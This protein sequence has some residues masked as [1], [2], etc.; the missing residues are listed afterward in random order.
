MA[1]VDDLVISGSAQMVKDFIVMIQEEFTLKHVNFLTSE[2]SVEFLGRTIK[3]LKNGNITME[4]SQKFIDELLKIFEVT[5]KVTTTGLK[6]QA[7]PEDQK[8]QCDRVIHQ[9]YRSAVGKLLWMAQLRDDLKYPVKELSRSLINPQDQDIK[10]L[11]HLLKY[12][13]QT[14]DFVFV[15]EPQ[16][17]VRNQEGKFPVQIVS[18]SDSD[19]AGCQKSR[20][21]TSGSLISVFN[22]NIQSTS[23]T[24]ASIAHSSAESELYAMTQASVESLA[25]KNFIQEFSSA[26][27]SA[28][29]SIVIQTDSSAGKSMASRLGI[30]R[31]SKHIELKYLWIQDEIKEG[32]L[33]LKKVGT[34]FNPSDVLT[35]Y[36]PAS[37]LGQHLPRLNIFKVHSQRSKSV[38]LSAQTG[39]SVQCSSHP[40]PPSTSTSSITTTPLSVFMFSVNLD[41]QEHLRQ[42]LSQASRRIKRVLTPPRRGSGDQESIALRRQH[43]SHQDSEVQENQE[44]IAEVRE[45]VH[46]N[47]DSGVHGQ[48]HV[49]PQNHESTSQWSSWIRSCFSVSVS[50]SSLSWRRRQDQGRN[51]EN[52]EEINQRLSHLYLRASRVMSYVLF[53]SVFCSFVIFLFNSLHPSN[54]PSVQKSSA[55]PFVTEAV[56]I[57]TQHQSQSS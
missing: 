47:S 30:S 10:N 43:V 46:E 22:V 9:K 55:Q 26:I 34:H 53:Y 2:N 33:E 25:I 7:L 1:Y 11:I 42:R 29:V 54:Q 3:R 13:N 57:R 38:L 56:N 31:R 21:S 19:W 50:L 49:P 14:R 32:K 52:Q 37:V 51:Q 27:L 20:R 39:Q 4:F 12:V 8:V 6:L 17:P 24:Q 23:R 18:Y 35:K 44:S 45:S 28:S 15:M 36:V 41:H 5:G 40:Q 16:L 48:R